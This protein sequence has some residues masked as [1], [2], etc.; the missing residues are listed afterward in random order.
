MQHPTKVRIN[1]PGT[2]YDMLE[3]YID[4][5]VLLSAHEALNL[6]RVENAGLWYR[7]VTSRDGERINVYIHESELIPV[8]CNS[9]G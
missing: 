6:F 7:I 9:I 3:G 2:I 8:C 5:N 1:K 4:S